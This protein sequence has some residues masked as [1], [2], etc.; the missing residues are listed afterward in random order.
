MV[1]IVAGICAS[2]GLAIA[3]IPPAA[4]DHVALAPFAVPGS[5]GCFDFPAVRS[6][7]PT[8]LFLTSDENPGAKQIVAPPGSA[9]PPASALDPKMPCPW[10]GSCRNLHVHVVRRWPKR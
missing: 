6:M 1:T 9:V 4:D 8:E 2:L 7:A 5:R 3:T 10:Q